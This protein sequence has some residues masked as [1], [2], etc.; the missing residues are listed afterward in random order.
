MMMEVGV[1]FLVAMLICFAGVPLELPLWSV[2]AKI[3]YRKSAVVRLRYQSYN[4]F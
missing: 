2:R 1:S 3:A 4:D